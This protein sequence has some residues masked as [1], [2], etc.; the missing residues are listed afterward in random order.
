MANETRATNDSL[1]GEMYLR[2]G[3]PALVRGKY[4]RY[5]PQIR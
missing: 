3:Q 4:L 2:V 5:V 1:I